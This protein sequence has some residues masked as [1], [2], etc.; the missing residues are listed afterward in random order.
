MSVHMRRVPPHAGAGYRKSDYETTSH[1]LL[2][3]CVLLKWTVAQQN[4]RLK[5]R[6]EHT[7]SLVTPR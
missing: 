2:A 1:S 5:F 4:L 3:Q 7:C 6:R